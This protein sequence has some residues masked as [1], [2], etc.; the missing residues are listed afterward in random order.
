MK[1][2]WAKTAF[3][4][5]KWVGENARHENHLIFFGIAG[6]GA[7]QRIL[8]E[9]AGMDGRQHGGTERAKARRGKIAS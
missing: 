1:V 8:Q 7:A 5:Q 2:Y 6:N 9:R 4:Q 3:V